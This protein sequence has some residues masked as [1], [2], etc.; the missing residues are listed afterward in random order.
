MLF[1][2]YLG[3]ADLFAA[4]RDTVRE[5]VAVVFRTRP[6]QVVVRRLVAESDY[7]GVEV[8]VEIS[9]DDQLYRYGARLAEEVSAAIR[10]H[11]E[12]DV[13]VLFRTVP[14]ERAFLNGRPRRRHS[15]PLA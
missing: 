6:E 11:H 8:W 4:T 15:P 12:V 9:S 7:E 13:W 10:A 1:V 14:L 2:D 5:R 3:P